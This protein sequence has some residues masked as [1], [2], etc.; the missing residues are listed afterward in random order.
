MGRNLIR[1]CIL[2]IHLVA[3]APATEL[4]ASPP[5]G[6]APVRRQTAIPLG[7]MDVTGELR[8]PS[9]ES[10]ERNRNAGQWW[11]ELL[12]AEISRL[13][14]ELLSHPGDSNDER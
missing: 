13:E 5:T 2:C 9:L 11:R 4:A 12:Q 7:S 8:R 1:T 14:A 3:L 6:E 10:V